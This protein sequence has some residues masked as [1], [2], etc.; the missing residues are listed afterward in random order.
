M[1]VMNKKTISYNTTTKPLTPLTWSDFEQLFGPHGACGGCWCMWFRLT[2]REFEAQ[3]GQGNKRAIHEIVQSGKSPGLLIYQQNKPVGWCAVAPR[4][5]Y[6]RLQRSRILKPIDEKP[7]WSLVCFF[8]ASEY[9]HQGLSKQLI[10]AAIEYVK[11]QGGHCVEAY[12]LDVDKS[13]A[14]TFAYHGLASA[15]K[16]AGFIEVAR[17]SKTRPIMRYEID[18][19]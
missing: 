3:K 18:D 12:P 15:F 14:D 4:D 6:A 7:V 5:E 11:R 19:S 2:N 9:R 10:R 13:Y 8:I 1:I 17:R 16:E